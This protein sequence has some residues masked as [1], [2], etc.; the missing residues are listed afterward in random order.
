MVT[1]Y[2][3]KGCECW[4]GYGKRFSVTFEVVKA[5]FK[6]TNFPFLRITDSSI[7]QSTTVIKF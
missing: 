3:M 7:K 5:S 2:W 6:P 4:D 1:D